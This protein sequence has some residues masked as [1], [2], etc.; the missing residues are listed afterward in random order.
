MMNDDVRIVC[1]AL[2][3]HNS[4]C[5]GVRW[6]YGVNRAEQ[7][8][9]LLGLNPGAYYTAPR[10]KPGGGVPLGRDAHR[11]EAAVDAAVAAAAAGVRTIGTPP[12]EVERAS[13]GFAPGRTYPR[14]RGDSSGVWAD[15]F[16]AVDH[17]GEGL[18]AAVRLAAQAG[19]YPVPA[20]G[21]LTPQEFVDVPAHA[22]HGGE[23]RWSF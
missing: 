9:R 1:A 6:P 4:P 7:A 19:V 17:D 8:A 14:L 22:D 15:L 2:L 23:R 13:A 5:G 10:G 18:A 21:G 11:R 20:R 16:R 12:T 3:T